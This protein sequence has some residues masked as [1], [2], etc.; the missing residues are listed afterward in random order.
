[1]LF[2]VLKA[3]CRA[4]FTGLIGLVCGFG[5]PPVA[6][7]VVGAIMTFRVS[8][9]PSARYPAEAFKEKAFLPH[10]GRRN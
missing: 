10:I 3:I 5:G 7:A 2:Y 6:Q 8:M 4:W 9:A 1:V